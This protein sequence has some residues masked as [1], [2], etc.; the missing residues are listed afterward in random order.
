MGFT[1]SKRLFISLHFAKYCMKIDQARAELQLAKHCGGQNQKLQKLYFLI[2]LALEAN[3]LDCIGVKKVCNVLSGVT[4][5]VTP[6]LNSC[7]Y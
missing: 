4:N 2:L 6:L 1:F 3:C 5:Q 7:N